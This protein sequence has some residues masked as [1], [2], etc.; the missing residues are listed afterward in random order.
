MTIEDLDKDLDIMPGA[1]LYELW[2]FREKVLAILVSDLTEFRRSG[3]PGTFT[4]LCCTDP[5]SPL[6]LSWLDQYIESI[7]K[8]PNY[9]DLIEFHTAMARHIKDKANDLSCECASIPSGT[10][11]SFWEA[12]AAVVHGS[13]EK[14][15]MVGVQ[16]YRTTSGC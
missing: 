2:K 9:F 15:S 11:R 3:L 1:Y 12:L 13:F 5:S 14:V 6:I 16:S 10:I 7:G 4:G 8:A